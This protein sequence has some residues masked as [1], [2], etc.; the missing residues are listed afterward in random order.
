MNLMDPTLTYTDEVCDIVSFVGESDH[1]VMA[2]EAA[3]NTL[4]PETRGKL[5][6]CW[7]PATKDANK[8]A[9]LCWHC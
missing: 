8:A 4:F 2:H 1:T 7:L 3:C 9:P 6:R 5:M